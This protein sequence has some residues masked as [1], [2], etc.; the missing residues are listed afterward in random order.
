MKCREVALIPPDDKEASNL[1]FVYGT[2]KKGCV[3][4]HFLAGAEFLGPGVTKEKYAL[5]VGE[6]PCVIKSEKISNIYGEIYKIGPVMLGRIDFLEGH[7]LE[8]QREKAKIIMDN[9]TEIDS[10]LYFKNEKSGTLVAD[11]RYVSL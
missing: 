10:W 3:N 1:I 4:H 2:L 7:P 6:Y 5:Y 9:G 11:G 8:Y